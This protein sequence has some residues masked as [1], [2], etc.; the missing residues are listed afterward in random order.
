MFEQS[1]SRTNQFLRFRVYEAWRAMARRRLSSH[2]ALRT[3]Y[4]NMIWKLQAWLPMFNILQLVPDQRRLKEADPEPC[5]RVAYKNLLKFEKKELGDGH[6]STQ[7][8]WKRQGLTLSAPRLREAGRNLSAQKLRLENIS[9]IGRFH[10]RV[11]PR[12]VGRHSR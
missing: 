3:Q 4:N 5:P 12:R 6:H 8:A 11:D 10:H 2:L 1:T 7:T 9:W